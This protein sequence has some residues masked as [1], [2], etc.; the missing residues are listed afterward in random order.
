MENTVIDKAE[1]PQRESGSETDGRVL[2]RSR[3]MAAVR[4]AIVELLAERAHLSI[5]IVARRAGVASRSVYRYYGV[6]EEAVRDAVTT[7]LEEEIQRVPEPSQINPH[8]DID[9]KLD[10]V[11]RERVLMWFEVAPLL[12]H[13]PENVVE[14][15]MLRLDSAVLTAFG[16]ELD[17]LDESVRASAESALAVLVRMRT[18]NTLAGR[19]NRDL[20]ETTAALRFAMERLLAPTG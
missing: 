2:R 16:P 12:G 6:L 3:N 1:G 18:I 10:R 20:T 19:C 4:G 5:P 11:S 14:A 9:V 17:A 7:R 15:A 13:L 8:Q